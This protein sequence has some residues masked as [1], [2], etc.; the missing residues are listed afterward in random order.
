MISFNNTIPT[1]HERNKW[2]A[3]SNNPHFKRL[4]KVYVSEDGEWLI[5]DN[6]GCCITLEDAMSVFGVDFYV[7]RKPWMGKARRTQR[8]T[9]H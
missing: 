3:L 7:F 5:Y 2:V 6:Y 8:P 9:N 1:V 4:S